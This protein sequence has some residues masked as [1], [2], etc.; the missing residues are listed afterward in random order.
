[1]A[2][3]R[4]IKPDFF[5]SVDVV[6]LTPLARLL[7]IATWIEADREG[8]MVWN[9]KTLKLRY[10]PGDNC[11]IEELAG[12]L[13]AAGLVIPYKIDEHL[14]AEIPSFTRHQFINNRESASLI[15]PRV[16]DASPTREPRVRTPL[17]G[18]ERKGKESS[19]PRKFSDE[20]MSL[21]NQMF[22][23]ILL[24]NPKHKKPDL[25]KWADEIRLMRERD[26]RTHSDIA[27]LFAWAN[28]DS[29]WKTNILSPAKLRE[30]WD[31]L[32]IKR[33]AANPA[34]DDSVFEGAK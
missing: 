27:D 34:A 9:P 29:F 7:Y 6:S 28:A 19:C 14:Y 32:Q 25:E 13:V 15:P 1:M 30:K 33:A 23:K 31:A 17:A 11:D 3:I 4:T 18:R 26:S 2:R 16:I 10:L 21:A 12:E 8:R 5:T 20:D 22:E 24:L